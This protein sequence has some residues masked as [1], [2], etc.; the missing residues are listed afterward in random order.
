MIS[1][2]TLAKIAIEEAKKSDHRFRLGVVVYSKNRILSRDHN[3]ALKSAKK[4]HPRFRPWPGSIHAEM[5]A[6]LSARC[7]L[8]D[9]AMF[10]L[11]I[12][13]KEE[14]MMAKPC[15][16]CLS[17][18]KFVGIKKVTYSTSGG[19]ETITIK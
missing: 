10:I 15:C 7:D 13:K 19:F 9:S 3:Y 17:Y 14:F 8:M 11:R 4:L 16:H 5:A 1:I 12:N 18:M 2:T 6:I